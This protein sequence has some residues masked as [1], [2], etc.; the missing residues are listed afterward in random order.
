MRR[1]LRQGSQPPSIDDFWGHLSRGT[2]QSRDGAGFVTNRAVGKRIIGFLHKISAIHEQ[3]NLVEGSLAILEDLVC[4]RAAD[5][6][7]LR[8]NLGRGLSQRPGVFGGTQHLNVGIVVEES[9]FRAPADPHGVLRIEDQVDGSL[10]TLRPAGNGAERAFGKVMF[11]DQATQ[12]STASQPVEH[13]W[14]R[15]RL[16]RRDAVARIRVTEKTGECGQQ[17]AGQITLGDVGRRVHFFRLAAGDGGIV[18]A[19]DDNFGF[20]EI[21]AE[22]ASGLESVHAR[23]GDVHQDEGW[24]QSLRSFNTL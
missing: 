16:G 10:E 13:G 5:V 22:D 11:L 7:N 21:S 17:V 15:D 14:R 9:G 4:Q 23:H 24:A 3:A 6:P 19:D 1:K 20:G 2:E 18:L 12:N 8:P